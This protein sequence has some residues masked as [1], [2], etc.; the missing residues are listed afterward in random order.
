MTNKIDLVESIKSF[1]SEQWPMILTIV[2]VFI[3]LLSIFFIL[4]I[5]FNPPINNIIQKEVVVES[6]AF[7]NAFSNASSNAFSNA[8]SNAFSNPSNSDN[9]CNQF[10]SQSHVLDKQ[11]NRLTEHNCNATNC[12]VWLTTIDKNQSCVAGGED[13]PTFLSSG[14]KDIDVAY[15]SFKGKI[16][17]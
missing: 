5:N 8:S 12:C 7:G 14:G 4:G 11:C 17:T 3:T 13:G 2:V 16:Q 15:Y 6:M 1:L 9:F 10:S